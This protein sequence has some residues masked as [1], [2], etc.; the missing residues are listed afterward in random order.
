[1]IR[2][3]KVQQVWYSGPAP[4]SVLKGPSSTLTTLL[5]AI[6]QKEQAR[7]FVRY[8]SVNTGPPR[9]ADSSRS[10]P[11]IQ[12]FIGTSPVIMPRSIMASVPID[13]RDWAGIASRDF[14]IKSFRRAAYSSG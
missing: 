7:F 12:F 13:R 6:G 9:F 8:F 1:M 10:S 14:V 5:Q 11:I 4:S 2:V 3:P